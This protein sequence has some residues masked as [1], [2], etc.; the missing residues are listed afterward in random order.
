[1][2]DTATIILAIQTV[3][4]LAILAI[5]WV[6]FTSIKK[7]LEEATATIRQLHNTLETDIRP[8][9][10]EARAAIAKADDMAQVAS[11]TFRAVTP[12]VETAS[13]VA[14][15]LQRSVSPLWW[16]VAR[17][18]MGILGVV[19]NRRKAKSAVVKEKLNHA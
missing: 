2:S 9:L 6:S 10:A 16:D 17:V 11:G 5:A 7:L 18:G 4:M 15:V 13:Q 19:R 14:G 3:V 12:A 8:A 1:M